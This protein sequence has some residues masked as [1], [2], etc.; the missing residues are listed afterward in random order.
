MTFDQAVAAV[1]PGDGRHL[2]PGQ[3]VLHH[4][5]QVRL[6]LVSPD[7]E[8]DWRL[9]P[10]N[11]PLDADDGRVDPMVL[12]NSDNHWVLDVN[13]V[14]RR[15]VPVGPVWGPDGAEPDR[16]DALLHKVREQLGLL[17]MRGELHLDRKSVVQGNTGELG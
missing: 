5:L 13:G 6:V 2:V 8:W 12:R 7:G 11:S 16:L 4:V 3:R 15:L 9:P 17:E 14:F 1:D 10:L